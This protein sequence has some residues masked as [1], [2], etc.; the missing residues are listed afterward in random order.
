MFKIY[1]RDG[2]SVASIMLFNYPTINLF[3]RGFFMVKNY[4]YNKKL[5][6]KV[7]YN[8]KSKSLDRV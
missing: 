4:A 8:G 2:G 1:G 7:S 5:T 6:D 3:H